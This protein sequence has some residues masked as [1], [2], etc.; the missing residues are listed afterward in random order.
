MS[1]P[2]HDSW[3]IPFIRSLVDLQ[4]MSFLFGD[5]MLQPS[6]TILSLGLLLYTLGCTVYPFGEI[7]WLYFLIPNNWYP[8]I[9]YMVKTVRVSASGR[10]F[11][12]WLEML[13]ILSS[14]SCW[15]THGHWV[16]CLSSFSLAI[17]LFCSIPRMKEAL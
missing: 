8:F 3:S 5:Y 17:H 2:Y 6:Y 11:I 7:F 14:S 16:L 9:I 10:R 1:S 12:Q 13:W 4:C 15:L